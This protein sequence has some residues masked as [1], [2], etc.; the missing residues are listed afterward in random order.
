MGLIVSLVAAEQLSDSQ[1]DAM[2]QRALA[3][4]SN[5]LILAKHYRTNPVSAA[6]ACKP[7]RNSTLR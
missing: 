6:L 4:D 7:P 2:V 5:M 1:E 3:R